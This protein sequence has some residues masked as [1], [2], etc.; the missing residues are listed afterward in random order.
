MKIKE[1]IIKLQ[2]LDLEKE[3]LIKDEHQGTIGDLM[4][5]QIFNDEYVLES[6]GTW[7]YLLEQEEGN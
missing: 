7:K 4:I 2:T 5:K 6:D 1:L 3:I